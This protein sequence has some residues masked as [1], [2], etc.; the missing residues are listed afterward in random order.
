MYHGFGVNK[1]KRNTFL[2][3]LIFLFRK[4]TNELIKSDSRL[5]QSTMVLER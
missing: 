4:G 3:K 5:L 2:K 1:L